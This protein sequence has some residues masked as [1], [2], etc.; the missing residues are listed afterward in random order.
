MSK[1]IS[2]LKK[3]EHAKAEEALQVLSEAYAYYMPEDAPLAQATVPGEKTALGQMYE[4]Y[5]AA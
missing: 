1:I 3:S 5:S 4:Y 2:F